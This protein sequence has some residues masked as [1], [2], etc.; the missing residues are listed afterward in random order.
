MQRI[1]IQSFGRLKV[2]CALFISI[3]WAV[4]AIQHFW[5]KEQNIKCIRR[6]KCVVSRRHGRA[7]PSRARLSALTAT[8][9]W[10]NR[11]TVAGQM[12]RDGPLDEIFHLVDLVAFLL[13]SLASYHTNYFD[14]CHSPNCRPG[15]AACCFITRTNGSDSAYRE[16]M[17]S[18]IVI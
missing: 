14:Y 7:H 11:A 1:I 17:S 13:F 18:P 5:E 9:G 8:N 16:D 3:C 2:F 10:P 15:P 6:Y 4:P 12:I